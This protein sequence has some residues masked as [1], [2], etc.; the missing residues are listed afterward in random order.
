[1]HRIVWVEIALVPWI[2]R[3]MGMSTFAAVGEMQSSAQRG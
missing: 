2:T 3:T 1:M